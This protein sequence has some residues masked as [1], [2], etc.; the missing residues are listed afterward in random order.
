MRLEVQ[1]HRHEGLPYLS[2]RSTLDK[3][4]NFL[5]PLAGGSVLAGL[6]G[7]TRLSRLQSLCWGLAYGTG[8]PGD[9][10]LRF[11]AGGLRHRQTVEAPIHPLG[12]RCWVAAAP[13]VPATAALVLDGDEVT[14]VRLADRW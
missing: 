4:Q 8:L 6:F 9:A 5:L 7:C 13:G 12:A 14:G 10:L 11:E 1:L 2:V 3:R